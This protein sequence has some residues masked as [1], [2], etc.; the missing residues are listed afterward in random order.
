MRRDGFTLI[1]L[2]VVIAIIGILAVS[3]A[4]ASAGNKIAAR[5]P[6]MAITTSN[7]IKVKPSL[8]T[9]QSSIYICSCGS[10]SKDKRLAGWPRSQD[11]GLLPHTT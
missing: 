11:R 2:L 9:A 7:S 1:E 10:I 4:R 8:R 5:I 3:R 6:I